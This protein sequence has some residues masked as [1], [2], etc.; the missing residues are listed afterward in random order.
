MSEHHLDIVRQVLDRQ[1]IDANQ[2]NCGKVDDVELDLKG[3]TPKV[4]ALLIGNQHS[5]DRLPEFARWLSRKL[6]GRGSTRIPWG[7]VSIISEEVKLTG[8]A[9]DYG[10]DERSGLVYKLISKL[11]GAWKK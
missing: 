7:D 9:A 10:L 6:F 11:P 8:H 4:T 2:Y 5:S 1:I 3:K